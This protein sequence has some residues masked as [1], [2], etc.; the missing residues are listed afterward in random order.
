MIK[1]AFGISFWSLYTLGFTVVLPT[2]LYY[3]ESAEEPPQDS[4]T[5][6][7][8]YLG[9]G[10]VTWLVAIG[11]YLRFFI[12][13]VFTDK[14]RLER[15]AREG[16]TI[17]AEIIRKTQV[18]VIHDAVTLDLRLAFRNLAGTPVEISYELNDSRPYERRFEA[19]NMID[20]SAGLN[21]GE[22]VFVPKALQVSRN[23]G[24]VI[25]YSFIL[26]LLLAAAIVYPVFAYMQ[27]SQG[28]GWRFLRLSHPWISVPLINIGVGALILV[29]LGFIGKASGETDKPLRMIMY[30]IKTTGTVLSYQQTGMYINEQ[31]Q[32]RFEIEYTDQT[33]YRRTT[34]CKKIVSLLDIH[35][36]DNGP[37]EIMYLPD[38]PEKIV[39]YDDL[40]L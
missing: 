8:L 9:L 20:M 17:T 40:T 19:G 5:I 31:P 18:G 37:K 15:T 30:G 28:T 6:A 16:T 38:K 7:F 1:P 36:L 29:F 24:I 33:G 26:L 35:K 13:L 39:F 27:E 32:V 11:L 34:V 22:A 4:A 12:K 14:Y 2:F 25:L 23:R 3:T 21:G 10:V